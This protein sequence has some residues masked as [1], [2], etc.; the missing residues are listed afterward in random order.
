MSDCDRICARKLPCTHAVAHVDFPSLRWGVVCLLRSQ[1]SSDCRRYVLV[2][3]HACTVSTM[4]V[5][6]GYDVTDAHPARKRVDS[7]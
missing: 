5:S 6:Q 3:E 7:G 1:G 4:I 2:T